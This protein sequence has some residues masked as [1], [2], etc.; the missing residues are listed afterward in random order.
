M[1]GLQKEDQTVEK[2]RNVKKKLVALEN[3][4]F[5]VEYKILAKFFF[6]TGLGFF[7]KKEL[8]SCSFCWFQRESWGE[9]T[10]TFLVWTVTSKESDAIT[11]DGWIQKI[12]TKK[13]L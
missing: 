12:S 1:L 6:A 4:W 9:Y 11:K 7:S 3:G 2:L 10:A 5:S 8:L 13:W